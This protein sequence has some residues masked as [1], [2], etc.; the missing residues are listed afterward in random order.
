MGDTRPIV[1]PMHTNCWHLGCRAALWAMLFTGLGGDGAQA[2]D[3]DPG[4]PCRTIQLPSRADRDR[5]PVITAVGLQPGGHLLAMAG[6]DHVIYVWDVTRQQEVRRLEGH[7]DWVHAV[8]FSPDGRSLASAGLDRQVI[9]WE[10]ATGKRQ[11]VLSGP[12]AAVTKLAWSHD[13]KRLVATGFENQVRVYDTQ[14]HRLIKELAG[15]GNDL[16]GL[17][18]SP[19]NRLLAVG[20]RS[21]V[22]RVWNVDDFS[23]RLEYP[24]HRQ[25]IRALLFSPDSQQIASVGEDQKIHVRT[26]E[27]NEGVD[28]PARPTKLLSLAFFGPHQLAVGGSDNLIRLWDLSKGAEMGRLAGHEGSVAALAS[29][30]SVLVSGAYDTTVR[31]WTIQDRVAEHSGGRVR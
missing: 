2:N 18:L 6:D 15:P 11:A 31:I 29:D 7:E 16:R 17:A 21:G 13:G 9:F 24:A 26:L 22:V 4:W 19:D 14:Q 8:A 27:S 3:H 12:R 30:H 23:Q 25:R 20:G 28:L 5:P 10:V 1:R